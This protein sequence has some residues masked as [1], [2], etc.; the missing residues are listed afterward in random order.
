MN[1]VPKIL[2]SHPESSEILGY[3]LKESS[4]WSARTIFGYVLF[5]AVSEEDARRA[6]IDKAAGLLAGMW[7]YFDEADNDWHPCVI[8]EMY[9]DRV[10]VLRT[11]EL[12]FHS[13]QTYKIISLHN[14]D[15]TKLI[16][17]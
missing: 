10:V 13:Q 6:V 7:L 5:R 11:T 1:D 3:V 14:P 17:S 16:P 12:G 2:V 8:K 4:G 9:E 15:E